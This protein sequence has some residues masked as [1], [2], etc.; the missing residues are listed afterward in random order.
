[1]A[2][3]DSVPSRVYPPLGSNRVPGCP[4]G[5]KLA[6]GSLESHLAIKQTRTTRVT[7]F[8][9]YYHSHFNFTHSLSQTHSINSSYWTD[10]FGSICSIRWWYCGWWF[11]FRLLSG[12]LA[13]SIHLPLPVSSEERTTLQRKN[14]LFP[15][16]A[17]TTSI[18][19]NGGK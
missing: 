17:R 11:P 4:G 16:S 7:R 13:I 12:S 3:L 1:M 10:S 6:G 8:Y 2:T 15:R 5:S 14:S 19:E 18:E 9:S